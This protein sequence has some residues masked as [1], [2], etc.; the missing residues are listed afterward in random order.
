MLPL[1][2]EE[3]KSHQDT[4]T[5]YSFGKKILK[6]LSKKINYQKVK[7]HCHC[8]RKYRCEVHSICH[9]KFNVPN[10]IPVVS[11]NGSLI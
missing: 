3:L 4:R 5:S 6:I 2:K 8:T 7:D 9:L 10:E 1:A 11:H